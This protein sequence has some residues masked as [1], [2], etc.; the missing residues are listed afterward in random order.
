MIFE[1]SL[2]ATFMAIIPKK[3]GAVD[4]KD[5]RPFTLVMGFIRLLPKS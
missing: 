1:K 5:F 2:N 4:V 3:L